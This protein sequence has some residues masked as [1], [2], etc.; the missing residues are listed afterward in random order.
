MPFCQSDDIQLFYETH[1]R[2]TA[3]VFAH[4][5]GGNHMSWWQQVPVFASRYRCVTFDHRGFGASRDS[6]ECRGQRAFASDMANLLD[7]LEIDRAHLV[8]QSMGGRSCLGFALRHPERV[9]SLTLGGTT[10][11]VSEPAL[12]EAIRQF[13]APP[14]ELLPR[15]L[16]RR[17]R[18]AQPSLAFLYA[19]IEAQNHFGP[20]PTPL[21]RE[22]PQAV[23]LAAMR[24]PVLM[25]TGTEDPI[26]PPHIVRLMAGMIPGAE[27]L[28]VPGCGHSVY[29]EEPDLFNTKVL[30]FIERASAGGAAAR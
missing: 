27:V 23:D 20:P 5:R 22:G 17:F 16:G 3:V 13:G 26:A 15:V 14:A 24:M 12:L 21:T 7:H 10:A 18:D 30:D 11:D 8:A 2:G 29:F 6:D 1:G 4:G 9:L 28:E 19:Q 25:L